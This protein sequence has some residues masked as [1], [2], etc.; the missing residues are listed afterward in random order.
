[1]MCEKFDGHDEHPKRI[2]PVE[3][4]ADVIELQR[5]RLRHMVQQFITETGGLDVEAADLA[6][7][8]NAFTASV[9]RVSEH[10]QELVTGVTQ[11]ISERAQE[12]TEE[13]NKL[14]SAGIKNF[15]MRID[16][17]TVCRSQATMTAEEAKRVLRMNGYAMLKHVSSVAQS[18]KHFE[19]SYIAFQTHA[20]EPD[21]LQLLVPPDG[22]LHAFTALGTVH[23][24]DPPIP[25]G[26]EMPPPLPAPTQSQELL[27][28]HELERSARQFAQQCACI[29][30]GER[31]SAEETSTSCPYGWPKHAWFHKQQQAPGFLLAFFAADPQVVAAA[32]ARPQEEER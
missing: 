16:E 23:M 26:M 24:G 21:P 10:I 25:G 8:M 19:Q 31:W 17:L 3:D 15:Q 4:M 30:C 11:T 2:K 12:L 32:A 5:N 18:A 6:K 1:M 13:V 9:D 22:P 20:N 14:S 7:R 27:R 29:H 28:L